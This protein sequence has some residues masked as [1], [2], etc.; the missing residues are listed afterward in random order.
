MDILKSGI[1]T[2]SNDFIKNTKTMK[3][4]VKEL[5]KKILFSQTGSGQEA[6]KRH[7]SRG[8]LLPREKNKFFDRSWF[9]IF[10]IF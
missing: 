10:R 4:L 8:K 2:E 5:N 3:S 6:I 1:N 7:R 9:T